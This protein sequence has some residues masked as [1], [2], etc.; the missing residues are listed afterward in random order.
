MSKDRVARIDT[1]IEF[2]RRPEVI[3][4]MTKKYGAEN[5]CRI[6]TFGTLAAKQVVK[7]VARVL[8]M[9]AYYGAKLSDAIPK[10]PKMTIQKALDTSPDFKKLYDSDS[11]AK[12][13]IDIAKRLEGNKRHASQHACFTADTFI[14]TKQGMKRS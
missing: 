13:I 7:D 8:G 14:T 5:V 3:A 10:A 6:V 11:K 4:Y 1:D 2:S 9:P 12:E